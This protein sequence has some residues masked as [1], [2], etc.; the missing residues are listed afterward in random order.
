MKQPWNLLD[1]AAVVVIVAGA[2]Y[3]LVG[4]D[5]TPV[6]G[7]PEARQTLDPDGRRVVNIDMDVLSAAFARA[8]LPDPPDLNGADPVPVGVLMEQARTW[9]VSRD[10]AALGKLGQV[11][12]ALEEHEAALGC[13]AA[14]ADLEPDQVL[15]R[16]DLGVECQAVRLHERAI[17][18]LE[19]ASRLDPDYPTTWARL[20]A[21]YLEAGDLDAAAEH[22][23]QYRGRA[24]DLA[25]GEVGLGRVALARGE[26]AEAERY[27]RA[28]IERSPG[29]FLAHRF[30]ARALALN[31]DHEGARREQD[32]AERLPQ[33]SGWLTFDPRL[34]AAH[35]I[36]DTQHYLSNQM[37]RAASARDYESFA[38]IAEGLLQRR[39]NDF[40]TL[41]NLATVYRGLRR[42]DDADAAIERALALKPDSAAAHRVRAEIAFAREDLVAAHRALDDASVLDP[43]S[44]KVLELRGRTYF[45]QGHE[46]E[47]IAAVRKAIDLD[48]GSTDTRVLLAIIL[49]K[50]GRFQ[51]AVA[52]ATDL[53]QR[54][55]GDR[56]ARALLKS[57]RAS[58]DRP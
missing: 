49:Q 15:W 11:Y 38:R 25:V 31:G 3:L 23:E 48:P 10:P 58:R 16:Y 22:Y 45:L 37:R 19:R 43:H 18:A 57:I 7:F 5:T 30:L 55:P 1:T 50:S 9:V 2:T 27:F 40:S 56:R 52:I 29:D 17:A 33:Y 12:Q 14:A 8:G 54:D 21:L 46:A 53:I 6:V 26:T 51:E 24:G 41:R 36:A 42:F 32:T 39:P 44:A 28:A 35:R 20:G 47:A 13:F 4:P 34:K